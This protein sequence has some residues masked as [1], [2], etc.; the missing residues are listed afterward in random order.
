MV[1][2]TGVRLA[3]VTE[4]EIARALINC[5]IVM[6]RTDKKV[7]YSIFIALIFAYYFHRVLLIFLFEQYIDSKFKTQNTLMKIE[8]TSS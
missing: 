7:N 3:R 4:K 2:R 6:L 5:A 1:H 8:S